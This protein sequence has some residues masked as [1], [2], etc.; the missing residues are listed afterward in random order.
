MNNRIVYLLALIVLAAS[1]LSALAQQG[2]GAQGEVLTLDEAISLA[3]RDSRQV[4]NS[5]LAVGKAGD[6]VAAA[7]TLRLPS[8][9][10]YSL[11]SQQFLKHDG[12]RDS[13][14]D[15]V[16]GV[17][18]LFSISTTRSPTA[19]FAGQILQPLSQQYRIRLG[20]EQAGLAREVEAKT[21]RGRAD[22]SQSS[23]ADLLRDPANPER[24]RQF[25]GS[26]RV[27]PRAG[28]RDGR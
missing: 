10:V 4:K 25:D 7:R 21:A 14:T 19:I 22:H 24:P 27:L 6:E 18:P 26:H 5:Q 3:L 9:H 28:S 13:E 11:V 8:M 20:I 12:G 17:G 1:P 15:I 16:P 2:A 23:Q